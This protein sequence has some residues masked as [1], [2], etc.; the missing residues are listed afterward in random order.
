LPEALEPAGPV[1]GAI[2]A[3]APAALAVPP[4]A[5]GRR[6]GVKPA[7]LVVDDEKL[8]RWTLQQCLASEGYRVMEADSG[9]DALRLARDE[10]PD[11]MILDLRLPGT[12]GM[13]VLREVRDLEPDLPVIIMTAHE[14]VDSAVRAMKLGARDYVSKP[15]NLE[16]L[17]VAIRKALEERDLRREVRH[18]RTE[19]H[20]QYGLDNVVAASPAMREVL[21][22][23]QKI[24]E[25]DATTVL[26]QGE[27]GTGKELVARAIHHQSA[28]THAPFMAVSCTALQDTLV[29]SELFGHE[30]GAFTDAKALK[31][32]LFELAGGGTLLL[33]E[34]GDMNLG[35]Q[36]KLLRAIETK[37]FTRVGGTREISVDIRIIGTTNRDLARQVAEASFRE[38]L[39]YRLKVIPVTI[40]PLRDRPEDILPLARHFLAQF[41][42]DSRK[43]ITGFTPR[44][45]RH[46]TEYPWPG[47][48]REVR[49]A[50]ERGVI[51]SRGPLIDLEDL[52]VEMAAP[53]VRDTRL[54]AR[55]GTQADQVTL[56]DV[57][58]RLIE[59]ALTTTQGNQV[60]AAKLLGITRDTLRYRMKK[61][62]LGGA[63]QE[64]G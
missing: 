44:A 27:S 46:M 49:N 22:L 35:A 38:D 45:E 64:G 48:V 43:A 33:D 6:S 1:G 58:R 36:A 31:R 57:E 26:I 18:L 52:P 7:V 17:K 39:Y 40:P 12:D 61:F 53:Q 16:E 56:E 37:A 42:R 8:I 50:I 62:G 11:L 28:R 3:D 20:H 15:L 54:L 34:I 19:Q 32:G 13:T 25:S 47:N 41:T 21:G 14:S 51:L 59:D 4:A 55:L 5:S 10:S 9:D 23:V 60:R 24:A 30:K 29:E 63:G 2:V